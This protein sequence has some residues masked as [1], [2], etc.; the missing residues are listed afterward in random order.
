MP[1][2]PGKFSPNHGEKLSESLPRLIMNNPP[3]SCSQLEESKII[4]KCNKKNPIMDRV[5]HWII[6]VFTITITEPTISLSPASCYLVMAVNA[7]ITV[8]L[9]IFSQRCPVCMI[10]LKAK[11]VPLN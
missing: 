9:V 3:A 11:G 5:V 8:F 6:Q 10:A 7:A 1:A 4:E 2:R